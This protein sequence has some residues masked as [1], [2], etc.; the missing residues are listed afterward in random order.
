MKTNTDTLRRGILIIPLALALFLTACA[1]AVSSPTP[2]PVEPTSVPA[3]VV[4]AVT[5]IPTQPPSTGDP[6]G[7][8]TVTLDLNGVAQ[9]VTTEVIPAVAQD[10]NGPWWQAMPQFTQLSLQG[11]PVS[12][13]LMQPQIFVYP[14]QGLAVNEVAAKISQ[15]LAALLES[16]QPGDNLPYLPLYNAAQVIHPQVKYLDFKNGKGVRYLT[17]FDQAPLLISNHELL[18]TYQGL[19]SDGKFYVAAVL[20]VNL[21]GLPASE[22]PTETPGPDYATKF[23]QYLSDTVAM[24]EGQPAGS[25][26]PDLSKLDALMQS[27]EVK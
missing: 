26:T 17:Q 5:D 16:Q 24:L 15:D 27:I 10:P 2:P 1:P 11:Y 8:P 25:F 21:P 9:A 4:A 6:Q 7:S 12:G 3:T 14:V 19:T 23:P 20:P 22:I 18:Y 13:S